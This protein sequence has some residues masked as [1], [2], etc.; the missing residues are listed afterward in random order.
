MNLPKF[1]PKMRMTPEIQKQLQDAN[2]LINQI[3][4]LLQKCGFRRTSEA[5]TYSVSS[6]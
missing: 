5:R 6:N 4:D 1:D 2:D 3:V